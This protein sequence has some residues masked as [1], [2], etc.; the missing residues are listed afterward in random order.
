MPIV[1]VFSPSVAFATTVWRVGCVDPSSGVPM[2]VQWDKVPYF[3]PI[4]II[5]FGL[6]QYNLDRKGE[7]VIVRPLANRATNA[8]RTENAN[9]TMALG[10]GA[11]V[12]V[13]LFRRRLPLLLFSLKTH[14]MDSEFVLELEKRRREGGTMELALFFKHSE[15]K[16]CVWSDESIKAPRL[17]A[18]FN[19]GPKPTMRWVDFVI[20]NDIYVTKALKMLC[21]RKNGLRINAATQRELCRNQTNATDEGFLPKS[22]LFKGPCQLRLHSL[23]Q[24][25]SAHPELFQKVANWLL[26]TQ[27]EKGGW[28]VPV[29]R[30]IA[31]GRHRL[32]LSIGWQSAMAQG[33][34]LSFLTRAYAM[35][36]NGE[37]ERF[38]LSAQ[39]ALGPFEL[40]SEKGGVLSTV[41]DLPWFEEYPTLPGTGVLNGFM[42]AL[43][44]LFDFALYSKKS[45]ALFIRGL[46]SLRKLLH[47]FD[48]GQWSLYDLRHIR[49]NNATPK[50][51]RFDY[52]LLHV[53][54]L[55][56]MFSITGDPFF[57]ETAKRWEKYAKG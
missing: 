3:Y 46:H 55:R 2:S 10:D 48:D 41:C 52:H 13:K 15:A 28:P 38:L 26:S 53:S 23:R 16:G 42:Y 30:V 20:D 31:E 35:A 32:V 57:E 21:A 7:E 1:S 44:G 25:N 27:D 43:F 29:K 36:K 5:Q 50:R 11:T 22:L 34:A 9:G 33:L 47:L 51:A 18:V 17:S 24:Q 4:Q 8:V 39:K 40:P 6:G 45:R 56:W 14:R 19:I 54:Q 49:L 12:R 37:K